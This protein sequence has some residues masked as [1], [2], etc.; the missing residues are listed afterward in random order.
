[1]IEIVMV[2]GEVLPGCAGLKKTVKLAVPGGEVGVGLFV[3]G[4][5][6]IE[7]VDV[8]RGVV[9]APVGVGPSG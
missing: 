2:T 4:L 8:G 6:V 5:G 3:V 7:V 1:M 9:A